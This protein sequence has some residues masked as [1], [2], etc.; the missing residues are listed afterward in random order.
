MGDPSYPF[1]KL[2]MDVLDPCTKAPREN[3]YIVSFVHRLTNRV[4][5]YVVSDKKNSDI[6][7]DVRELI[8]TS[9][10]HPLSNSMV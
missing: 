9:S 10:Y 8:T 2:S 4:E 7:S 3:F 6:G 1:D 5:V